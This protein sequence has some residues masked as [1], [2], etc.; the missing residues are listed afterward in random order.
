MVELKYVDPTQQKR[1]FPILDYYPNG[2]KVPNEKNII[3]VSDREVHSMLLK[4]NGRSPCFEII[5]KR[6]KKDGGD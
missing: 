6:K 5:E 1:S 2:V 3:K 4:R